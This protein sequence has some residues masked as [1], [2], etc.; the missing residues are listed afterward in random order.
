M[1]ERILRWETD[2]FFF[3]NA[4]HSDFADT[5][6]FLISAKWPWVIVSILFLIFLFYKKPWRESL[7]IIA[8]VLLT[9]LI[10]DQLSSH[11][12]KPYFG[13]FRP[14]HHP[15]FSEF[16]KTSFSYRGGLYGFFS[17]HAA[18]FFGLALLS[19]LIFRNKIY[20]YLIFGIA[21]TV[22][23]SRIYL[24]VHFI[25]DIVMGIAIGLLTAYL[26]YKLYQYCRL[27]FLVP[28]SPIN[29]ADIIKPTLH[30]WIYTLI[31]F[32]L[33]LFFISLQMGEILHAVRSKPMMY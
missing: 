28:P 27:R 15:D 13:R 20:S 19:A 3:L 25:S 22:A 5:F 8:A 16:V 12:F 30:Y 29:H 10:C 24:G 11:M 7:M 33:L 21:I 4:P 6:F 26:V 17:G 14:T 18:N 1:L 2:A 9:V 23:Y 31:L 32:I